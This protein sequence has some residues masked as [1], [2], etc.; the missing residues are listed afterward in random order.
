DKVYA[1]GVREKLRKGMESGN[2]QALFNSENVI[3][4][5]KEVM[6]KLPEYKGKELNDREAGIL[7]LMVMDN[8]YVHI[9]KE[10]KPALKQLFEGNHNYIKSKVLPK[11]LSNPPKNVKS[12]P[13]DMINYVEGEFK[14]NFQNKFDTM[15]FEQFKATI[16]PITN[17]NN[18]LAYSSTSVRSTGKGT[19]AEALFNTGEIPAEAVGTMGILYSMDLKPDHEKAENRDLYF[20]LADKLRVAPEIGKYETFHSAF[21][22]QLKGFVGTVLELGE[23]KYEKLLDFYD[24]SA[25]D[26]KSALSNPTSEYKD[27]LESFTKF[28]KNVKESVVESGGVY[29]FANGYEM[30]STPD[31][32]AAMYGTCSN[33]TFLLKENFAIGVKSESEALALNT[34][35][36]MGNFKVKH[37]IYLIGSASIKSPEQKEAPNKPPFTPPKFPG[38]PGIP[39]FNFPK[40]NFDIPDNP[41]AKDPGKGVIGEAVTTSPEEQTDDGEYG[42]G[43]IQGS[44]E[45][46]EGGESW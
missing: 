1:S 9:W 3:G 41:D 10:N 4:A 12:T 18:Y 5:I 8:Y 11:L 37:N 2:P 40:P 20:T 26:Q 42:I 35:A 29:K 23:D 7:Y 13:A 27:A 15:T 39:N 32:K 21:A 45:G 19:L 33:T 44:D 14:K 43:E 24:L 28:A 34:L 36:T 17:Y 38:G 31:I 46:S 6:A 22:T 25:A 16:E 30:A